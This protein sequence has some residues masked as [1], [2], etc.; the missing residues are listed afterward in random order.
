VRDAALGLLSIDDLGHAAFLIVF[1]L[2]MWRV[3]VWQMEK[4]LID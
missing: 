1:A 2:A 3:A 4:K